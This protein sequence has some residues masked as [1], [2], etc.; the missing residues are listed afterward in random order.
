MPASTFN[1][2]NDAEAIHESF[3]GKKGCSE[4]Y[5]VKVLCSRT[6]EEIA[7]ISKQYHSLYKV[8]LSEDVKT[9]TSGDVGSFLS[10][11]GM[12]LVC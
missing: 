1:S 12:T 3:R 11:L 10:G 4:E 2:T 9:H 5:L 6:H 7:Q 8:S